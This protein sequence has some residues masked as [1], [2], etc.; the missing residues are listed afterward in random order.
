MKFCITCLERKEK[1]NQCFCANKKKVE[2]VER[3]IYSR[4]LNLY[5]ACQCSNRINEWP[6]TVC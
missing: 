4:L 1:E 3:S 6:E 5:Y 2:K